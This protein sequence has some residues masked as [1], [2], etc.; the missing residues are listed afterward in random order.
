MFKTQSAAKYAPKTRCQVTYMTGPS[1]PSIHFSC[2]EFDL[3]SKNANCKG[4]DKITV[5][6]DGKNEK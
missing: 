5:V 2:S 4:G 3:D 6:A 1:C